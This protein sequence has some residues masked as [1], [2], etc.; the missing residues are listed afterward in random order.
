MKNKKTLK[1][2][3]IIFLI[4]IG[5]TWIIPGSATDSTNAIVLGELNPTGI[6]DIFSSFDIITMY[7]A[8]NSI[9]VLLVGAFYAV[10]NKTGAYKT[11]VDKLSS[12]FKKK[13][14]MAL[15]I[16]ILFFGLTP[17]LTN[18]LFP[19]FI[20]LPLF[21]SVLVELGYNK[22]TILLSTVGSILIGYS[23]GLFNSKFLSYTETSEN[24]YIWIKLGYLVLS[25]V[26]LSM[27][28]LLMSN[29]KYKDK[30]TKNELSIVPMKRDAEKKSKLGVWLLCL[31][32]GLTLIFV[33]LGLTTWN[34]EIFK[35][36]NDAIM[37]VSIGSYKIFAN[38]FGAFGAFGAWTY[39]E[40][41]SVLVL[42]TLLL[43]LCYKL[44]FKE[45]FESMFEGMMKFA[46]IA[47]IIAFINILVVFTLNS[48]IL[49]TIINLFAKTGNNALITLSAFIGTPFVVEPIYVIQY[50]MGIISAAYAE[51]NPT[52]LGLISQSMYGVAMLFVPTSAILLSGLFYTGESYK[53]WIKHVWKLGIILLF[54]AFTAITIA[55]LIK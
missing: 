7:F 17:A 12:L 20:F 19:M 16:T 39:T 27:Y 18:V 24:I 47:L 14:W 2:L 26:A 40:L 33:I 15:L 25:M 38:I 22:K 48:G 4:V 46:N 44:N 32:F 28:T 5:L 9:L 8:Q 41:Y 34:T 55:S 10:A 29:K 31:V 21:I 30:E 51:M 49:A 1:V 43:A 6:A 36:M 37:N 42:A 53:G 13:K 23:A 3:G 35:N 50:N 52:L 11:L 45:F 54:L